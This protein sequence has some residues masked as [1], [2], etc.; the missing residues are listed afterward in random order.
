MTKQSKQ[1]QICAYLAAKGCKEVQ[2]KSAKYRTFKRANGEFYFV[3]KNGSLRTGP[4][5]SES[6]SLSGMVKL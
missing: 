3:G 1:Q 4:T 2:G 6:I 5:V